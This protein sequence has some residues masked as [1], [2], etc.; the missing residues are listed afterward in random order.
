[1][2]ILG[3]RKV[4][5]NVQIPIPQRVRNTKHLITIHRRLLQMYRN[6]YIKYGH[7]DDGYRDYIQIAINSVELKLDKLKTKLNRPTYQPKY[8][9]TKLGDILNNS[10]T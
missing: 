10:L 4:E 5:S 7:M 6:E 2:V 1:M 9:T 3:K 8:S